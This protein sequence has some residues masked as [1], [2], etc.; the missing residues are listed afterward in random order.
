MHHAAAQSVAAGRKDPW[1]A[2]DLAVDR[3]N[4]AESLSDP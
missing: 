3:K 1:I 2:Q 4:R